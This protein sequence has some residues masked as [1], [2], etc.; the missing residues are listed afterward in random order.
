MVNASLS[1]FFV[2]SE[3]TVEKK[4][5]FVTHVRENQ[6]YFERIVPDFIPDFLACIK[7][8]FANTADSA[9]KNSDAIRVIKENA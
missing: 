1:G 2:L 3:Q 7:S 6:E 8:F 9:R 4:K 5:Y